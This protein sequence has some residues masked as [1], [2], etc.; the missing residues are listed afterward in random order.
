M[1]LALSSCSLGFAAPA[2][3]PARPA[4]NAVTMRAEGEIGV[5]PPLGVYDPLGCLRT[6]VEYPRRDYSR[7][8]ELE[9]KHGRIAMHSLLAHRHSASASDAAS[10]AAGDDTNR[11]AKSRPQRYLLHIGIL[12]SQPRV[13]GILGDD[14]RN[15]IVTKRH[16]FWMLIE[17]VEHVGAETPDRHNVSVPM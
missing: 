14:G 10:D 1:A 9:I 8:V 6:P 15:N 13:L 7:Y 16:D 5:T 3:A 12:Q 17:V 4:C 2:L 11:D